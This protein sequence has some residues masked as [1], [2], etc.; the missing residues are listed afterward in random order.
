MQKNV[1]E[2]VYWK[3]LHYVESRFLSNEAFTKYSLWRTVQIGVLN[4]I[5]EGIINFKDFIS[6]SKLI[7]FF[8]DLK[9][10]YTRKLDSKL[11]AC[12]LYLTVYRFLDRVQS[13][14]CTTNGKFLLES[15]MAVLTPKSGIVWLSFLLEILGRSD[16]SNQAVFLQ[17]Q[18]FKTKI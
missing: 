8:V 5:K 10:L 13:P 14:T 16:L 18:K 4:V 2:R 6:T 1:C 15:I 12:M 7:L 9:L 11:F 3:K 17:D